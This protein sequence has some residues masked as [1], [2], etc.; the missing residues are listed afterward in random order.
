MN[1]YDNFWKELKSGKF[2]AMV[3]ESAKGRSISNSKEVY[4]ILKPLFAQEDDIEK[5]YFI[6][7][8]AKNSIIAIENLFTGTITSSAI[9]PREIIKKA[10][11]LK[12]TA[13]VMAHNHPSGDINPSSEDHHITR[14]VMAAASSID[15]QFHDHI[16]IGNGFHSMADS[17]RL[18]QFKT[19]INRA[20]DGNTCCEPQAAL[21]DNINIEIME[22]EL[23]ATDWELWGLAQELYWWVHLFQ[24]HFFKGTLRTSGSSV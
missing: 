18:N 13:F 24:A 1:N 14:K 21:S 9:Y 4:N 6:F 2:A 15:I 20:M 3:A 10:L 19:D 11:A 8:D 5:A 23:S 12:S 22:N 7:M 16:I 17:G